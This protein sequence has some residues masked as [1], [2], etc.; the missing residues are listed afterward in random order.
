M[1]QSHINEPLGTIPV[2]VSDPIL[3][4]TESLRSWIIIIM[5]IVLG[6]GCVLLYYQWQK[7]PVKK[8]MFFVKP[9]KSD[10]KFD[11]KIDFSYVDNKGYYSYEEMYSYWNI[12]EKGVLNSRDGARIT[13]IE[14]NMVCP[15]NTEK[16]LESTQNTEKTL[17]SIL[18]K[19]VYDELKDSCNVHGIDIN[20]YCN[21]FAICHLSNEYLSKF[22]HKIKFGG[23]DRPVLA[24]CNDTLL[25]GYWITGE[26]KKKYSSISQAIVFP[27]DNNYIDV[28]FESGVSKKKY[29]WN[30]IF[31]LEDISKAYY[32][33]ETVIPYSNATVKMD[34]VSDIRVHATKDI[35]PELKNDQINSVTI[36]NGL[37]Y[38][39]THRFYVNYSDMENLQT[40]RMFFL[41]ALITLCI[42]ALIKNAINLFLPWV[43]SFRKQR[44]NKSIPL[45]EECED[46]VSIPMCHEPDIEND[47]QEDC[48]LPEENN[49]KTNDKSQSEVEGN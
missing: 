15:Q 4:K 7:V 5:A 3:G 36:S 27:P 25:Y 2:I 10:K 44:K 42:S 24:S 9:I 12:E 32:V 14:K 45:E 23:K 8:H 6:F 11:F 40:I 22:K 38:T 1:E 21:V 41:A 48:H 13:S 17:E 28:N 46:E 35:Y 49:D 39:T 43:L 26:M 20:D 47:E 33:V 19:D 30:K 29:K 37:F 16:T 34:F 31:Q 18:N